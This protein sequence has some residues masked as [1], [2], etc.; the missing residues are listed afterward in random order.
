MTLTAPYKQHH[1]IGEYTSDAFATAFVVANGW[2]SGGSPRAG[3]MYYN[4][5]DNIFY[6]WNG[7]AW[8]SFDINPTETLEYVPKP[9]F[10]VSGTTNYQPADSLYQGGAYHIF[11]RTTFNRVIC[12]T[13]AAG[14][15]GGGQVKLAFYQR[16]DGL[17]NGSAIPR[18]GTVTSA[19]GGGTAN[20]TTYELTVDGGGTITLANGLVFILWAELTNPV[21]FLCWGTGAITYELMNAQM[22]NGTHPFLFTTNFATGAEPAN[23]DPLAGGANVT[24]T[25]A[26]RALL[27]RLRKV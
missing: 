4:T 27:L 26:A 24:A 1:Y 10:E 12:R 2:D 8:T 7:S 20:S 9:Q 15:A 17:V 25:T 14:N 3:M 11:S 19:I 21:G 13:G 18:V 22:F 5:T 6:F 23:L 16:S